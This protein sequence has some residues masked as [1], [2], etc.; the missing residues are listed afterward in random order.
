MQKPTKQPVEAN[1]LSAQSGVE[2]IE[3]LSRVLREQALWGAL[4][5]I[6]GCRARA[7]KFVAGP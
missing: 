2:E 1:A 6:A 4:M 5:L 7:G 3:E